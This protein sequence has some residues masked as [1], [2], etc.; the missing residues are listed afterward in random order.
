MSN[1]SNTV[2]LWHVDEK[3]ALQQL[4]ASIHMTLFKLLSRTHHEL[5]SN[6]TLVE[7]SDQDPATRYS[8]EA[9][10]KATMADAMQKLNKRLGRLYNAGF[11]ILKTLFFF[12]N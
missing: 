11:Q 6:K 2:Y 3:N 7:I 4:T 5:Q 10:R 9:D 8:G 12:E 1:P